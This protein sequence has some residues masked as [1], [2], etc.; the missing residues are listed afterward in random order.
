MPI[1]TNGFNKNGNSILKSPSTMFQQSIPPLS[2]YNNATPPPINN[3][4]TELELTTTKADCNAIT[5]FQNLFV[6]KSSWMWKYRAAKQFNSAASAGKKSEL[7]F[8]GPK[9]HQ[10]V[11]NYGNCA[12]AWVQVLKEKYEDFESGRHV[13]DSDHS[14]S[15]QYPIRGEGVF[16]GGV[17]P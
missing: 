13:E 11:S 17:A 7:Q 5:N 12:Q 4:I 10:N 3:H 14:S 1:S 16:R 9:F 15:M 2:C 8:L 6:T